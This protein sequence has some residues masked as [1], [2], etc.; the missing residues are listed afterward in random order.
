MKRLN[1]RMKIH[2]DA[3]ISVNQKSE[4]CIA[5]SKEASCMSAVSF[6]RL[7]LS[8]IIKGVSMNKHFSY[9]VWI[10][11]LTAAALLNTTFAVS[12]FINRAHNTEI[13]G[14]TGAL[15]A[16][17]QTCMIIIVVRHIQNGQ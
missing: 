13:A 2:D 1:K 5:A 14:L 11:F 12:T 6:A 16:I 8:N 17:Y 15:W 9:I 3:L 7:H 10:L 4:V